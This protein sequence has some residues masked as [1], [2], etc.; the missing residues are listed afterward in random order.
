MSRRFVAALIAGSLAACAAL[1]PSRA[2]EFL[3]PEV[4][5]EEGACAGPTCSNDALCCLSPSCDAWDACGAACGPCRLLP[6]LGGWQL[7]GWTN[8]G[9]MLNGDD[10]PSRFHGPYNQ[11]DRNEGALNQ[12]YFVLERTLADDGSLDLGGRIDMLYGTDF[13]L[14]Q[15]RGLEVNPGF[16]GGWNPEYYGLA[17]PQLYA[18]LGTDLVSLKL[19]HFYTLVGYEGVPAPVNFFYS[20]SYSYQF[21][22]PFTH[23]GGVATVRPGERLTLDAGLVNGWNAL[24]RDGDRV[25]FLGRINFQGDVG[26]TTFAIVTGD[27][28]SGGTP[29]LANRTRY[30]LI[31]TVTVTER[32]DVVIHP[33]AAFQQDDP[34]GL[35]NDA[36]EWYGLEQYAYFQLTERL[37]LGS[38]FE[39]MRDDDGTRIGLNRPSNPNK[40][41]FV[42]DAYSWTIGVNFVANANLVIRPEMRWDKFDGT[43]LP[44]DDGTQDHQ[45]TIGSDVILQY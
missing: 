9:V 28:S 45:F 42:G 11:V 27:E 25:N 38:R 32:L 35:P 2:A 39:W 3:G 29:A 18:E 41:P 40:P 43:G 31:Q 34:A 5:A 44:Y 16:G 23:W 19:G 36:A 26:T 8:G 15:S 14:A 22:G 30:G 1:E 37:R 7:Y 24:D 6:A 20:K 13:L 21:A 33:W 12:Q 4:A 17:F 10:P